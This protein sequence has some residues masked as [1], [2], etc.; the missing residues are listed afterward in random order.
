MTTSL[1]TMEEKVSFIEQETRRLTRL[2]PTEKLPFPQQLEPNNFTLLEADRLQ[3][4]W[5]CKYGRG[6]GLLVIADVSAKLDGKLW[7]HVSYS[8]SKS[9]PDYEDSALVKRV[10]I[11]PDRWA[12]AVYP[13]DSNH[14]NFHPNCLHL[15]HCLSDRPFPEFSLGGLV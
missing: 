12:I 10:F 2:I 1:S 4:S 11:G 3:R 14:V 7:Y 8:R 13:E 5:R 15:W 6:K 9:I